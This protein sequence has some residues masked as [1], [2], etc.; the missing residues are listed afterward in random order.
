[1]TRSTLLVTLILTTIAPAQEAP[2]DGFP[3]PPGAVRRFG[4]RQLRHPD[5]IAAL[6][7][8]PDGKL[9]AT[10]SFE[11]VV[12]WDVKT[13]AARHTFPKLPSRVHCLDTRGG[14]VTFLP[15]SKGLLV[16]AF[17]DSA[18]IDSTVEL[19]QVWDLATGKKTLGLSG[20]HAYCTCWP[21]ADGKELVVLA[22][23][24]LRTFARF[25]DAKDGK[26][27]RT[28]PV[29]VGHK[30]PCVGP[31][32]NLV[33][34]FGRKGF[35]GGVADVRTGKLV[36]EVGAQVVEAALSRDERRLAWVDV[37][38]T[39]HVYDLAAKKPYQFS[40]V[41]PVKD[42]PG[43]MAISAD[44]KTLYLTADY[45][46]LFRWDLAANKKGPDFEQTPNYWNVTA[47]TLSPD[48][49]TVFVAS[50]DHIVR[51]W[52]TKTGKYLPPGDG[53]AKQVAQA[54][55]ADGKHLVLG[56]YDGRIDLWDLAT[57]KRVRE[58]GT[59]YQ[60][61]VIC[62]A[63]SADG[64]WLAAG[65]RS[66]DV[67]LID[68][69]T[70]KAVPDLPLGDNSDAKWRDPVQQV[71]FNAAGTVVYA[72]S[73]RTGLTAWDVP[74]GKKLWTNKDAD[75]GSPRTPRAGG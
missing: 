69:T 15:D 44:G 46:R 58:L 2:A 30:P 56:D 1:M 42:R 10:A 45:G 73:G 65:R 49:S 38:G 25:Y 67:R 66:Q 72:A 18:R 32:G 48:E 74:A 19:A 55:A 53:Y 5:E 40:F 35:S 21:A 70:G 14:A 37:E 63:T 36:A 62:L 61:G 16:A 28:V 23:D 60:G 11:N 27:L 31:S 4:S 41:H 6:A 52:D 34:P 47:I 68:L 57:G 3:L 29:P 12:V 50:E 39:I 75:P 51:R 22:D 43:P 9:L 59:L 7:V 33:V 20:P 26:L 54:V 17:P 13:L 64:K 71:E 8:S 24:Q